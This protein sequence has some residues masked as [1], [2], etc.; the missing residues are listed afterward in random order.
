MAKGPFRLKDEAGVALRKITLYDGD[1]RDI[2]GAGAPTVTFGSG[3]PSASEPQGS[4]YLRVN[5]AAGTGV[6]TATSGAGAWSA[7]GAALTNIGDDT[8]LTFGAD[9]DISIEYDENGTDDLRIANTPG[10]SD[11]DI[12]V[13]DD[14]LVFLGT[15]KDVYVSYDEA[16][17]DTGVLGGTNGWRFLDAGILYFGTDKDVSIVHDGTTGLDVTVADNDAGALVVKQSSNAYLTI[18]TRNDRELVTLGKVLQCAAPMGTVA[19]PVDMAGAELT[20]VGG[21]AGAG[22]VKL[23]SNLILIDANFT[24]GGSSAQNLVLPSAATWVG[25]ILFIKNVGGENVTVNTSVATL[26]PAQGCAV[27]SDGTVWSAFSVA[28]IT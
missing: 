6:Y 15:D 13:A 3:A 22:Q 16:G 23:T 8:L 9:G 27:F 5:G 18:D 12:V 21:T 4:I 25:V 10:G 2:G 24:G 20:I 14:L 19:A 11:A 17:A 28:G 7:L 1:E 26:D